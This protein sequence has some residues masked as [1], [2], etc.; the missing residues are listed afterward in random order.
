MLAISSS[1]RDRSREPHSSLVCSVQ[2]ACETPVARE[3]PAPLDDRLAADAPAA[4]ESAAA[5]ESVA[6]RCERPARSKLTAHVDH[7][8]DAPDRSPEHA[9]PAKIHPES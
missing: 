6:A 1:L 9:A 2:A 7:P 3:S 4:H 5:G 8:P